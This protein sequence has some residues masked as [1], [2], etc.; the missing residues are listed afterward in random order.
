MEQAT[1]TENL[2]SKIDELKGMLEQEK[3]F[4]HGVFESAPVAIIGVSRDN[5][6]QM[7]NRKAEQILA[8]PREELLEMPLSDVIPGANPLGTDEGDAEGFERN[9][10][11]NGCALTWKSS[12]IR[13]DNGETIGAMIF[14]S[15]FESLSGNTV[16]T[17]RM[18]TIQ[19][20]VG[21]IAHDFNNLLSGIVGY[22]SLVKSMTRPEDRIFKSIEALDQSVKRVSSL[23]RQLLR[24][25]RGAK[26]KAMPL[27]IS[28]HVKELCNTWCPANN[29]VS[30]RKNLGVDLRCVS[31]DWP[32]IEEALTALLENA[33]ESMPEGGE[34]SVST[35]QM[36][37]THPSTNVINYPKPGTYVRITIKDTGDGMD[38]ETL[39]KA[40]MPFFSTR[41]KAKGSGMGIPT[42]YA[43]T[44]R[45]NGYLT[46]ESEPKK[47]TVASIYLPVQPIIETIDIKD[48]TVSRGTETILIVDDE[49][50]VTTRVAEM[51]RELGY[52]VLTANSGKQ[53]LKIYKNNRPG[54]DLVILDMMM[55]EMSGIETY[56]SL[57]N[58]DP[59]LNV[60]LTSGVEQHTLNAEKI[61][62]G[63]VHSFVPKPY[64]LD[65]L[66]RIIREN[67]EKRR[68]PSHLE[69][70]HSE[71]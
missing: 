33:A 69:K 46:L 35:E 50:E 9:L 30:V 45:H 58:I 14:G 21:G 52:S 22:S 5:K 17:E 26:V 1:R 56:G 55:P 40:Y 67:I 4:T 57:K 39:S 32:L 15:V 59:E 3:R 31:A 44:R 19:S 28:S 68:K 23:V 62:E 60:L 29:A 34:I 27:N 66:S 54:I 25:G 10:P 38:M 42:A 61:G 47:G 51:L 37:I 65:R 6:I 18:N 20:F 24:F 49:K 53:A 70:H 11:W 64:R 43:T 48:A 71:Q 36:E 63:S 7:V 41:N 13:N 8:K 12:L 2:Q 16:W